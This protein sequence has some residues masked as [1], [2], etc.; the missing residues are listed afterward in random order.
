MKYLPFLLLLL[1]ACQPSL[2]DSQEIIDQSIQAYNADYSGKKISF[3]FRDREYSLVREAGNYT[4][5]RSWDDDSLGRVKDVLVNSS[6]FTRLVEGDTVNLDD[7]WISRYSA[8][9]NSVLYF[10]QIPIILNDPAAIKTL[11]EEVAISGKKYYTIQVTFSEDGGG[12]DF[13]DLFM[14]WVSQEDFMVDFFAYSYTV[15]G[16]GVRFREAT[17]RSEL[18]GH[19]FQDYINFKAEI[20]TPL[21][22]LPMLWEAGELEELSRIENQNIRI[23]NLD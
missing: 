8:S 15:E 3:D 21:G 19:I 5:T 9:V 10:F 20:G 4:Y 7:E 23:L 12:E 11:K 22:E 14:Y 17:N 6:R 1:M 16:G 2:S 18:A 13:E